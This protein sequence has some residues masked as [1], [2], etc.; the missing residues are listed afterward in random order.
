[1]SKQNLEK[2][3]LLPVSL[4]PHA[5]FDMNI[6]YA[7]FDDTV[8]YHPALIKTILEKERHVRAG[9]KPNVGACG[10]KIYSIEEWDCPAAQFLNQ[11]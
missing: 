2:L 1:M 7:E 8:A 4:R 9:H 3:P 5:Q 10:S 6:M 11:P